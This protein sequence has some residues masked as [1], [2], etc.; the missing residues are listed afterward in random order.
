MYAHSV[1]I[2]HS[3]HTDGC[4]FELTAVAGD[5]CYSHGAVLINKQTQ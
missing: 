4:D 3:H 2:C 1:A 5:G